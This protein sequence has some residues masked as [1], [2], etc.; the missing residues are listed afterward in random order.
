MSSSARF[1]SSVEPTTICKDETTS[2]A[3]RFKL[4]VLKRPEKLRT[5]NAP[6]FAEKTRHLI[7]ADIL[8]RL[9]AGLLADLLA[10]TTLFMN[11]CLTTT[12]AS[13]DCML[14]RP[15]SSDIQDT[16][17]A[18]LPRVQDSACCLTSYATLSLLST[19]K[20]LHLRGSRSASAQ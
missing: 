18:L 11:L 10:S 1:A 9:I 14:W 16:V 17:M 2:Y 6:S 5:P 15:T 3:R 19:L 7:C 13:Q 12:R 4:A 20:D 8:A